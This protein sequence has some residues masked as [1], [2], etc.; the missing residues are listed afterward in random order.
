VV[1][2]ATSEL[3]VGVTDRFAVSPGRIDGAVGVAVGVAVRRP[4]V[5]VGCSVTEAIRVAAGVA[6]GRGVAVD[7]GVDVATGDVGESGDTPSQVPVTDNVT[8]KVSEVPSR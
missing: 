7:L 1:V 6:V 4:G 8:V 5:V 3:R 2:S